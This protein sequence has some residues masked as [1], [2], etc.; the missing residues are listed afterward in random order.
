MGTR[1]LEKNDAREMMRDPMV[2]QALQLADRLR[3]VKGEDLE[4]DEYFAISE[5][6]GVSEEYIRFLEQNKSSNGAQNFLDR[7]RT[8]FFSLDTDTRRYVSTGILATLF[9]MLLAIGLKIDTYTAFALKSNY[10]VFQT[11]S[12]V[13]AIGAFYNAAVSKSVKSA[14]IVGGIFGGLSYV[15]G[16]VFAMIMFIPNLNFPPPLVIVCA[17]AC[18]LLAMLLQMIFHGGKKGGSSVDRTS[19]RQDLLKQLVDL[20]EHLREGQQAATFLSLDVVGSTKMKLG[21]DPLSVEFTFTEY[22]NYVARIAEKHFG[23]IHSTA[24]DGITVAFEHP[25]NAFN[26]ARQIQ[27]GLVEFNAF[28]NKI[29]TPLQLRAGI[30][31]GQVLAPEAGNMNSINFASVIDIAAHLQ[32]ECPIGGVAVSDEAGAGLNGGPSV[33]GSERVCVHDTWATVWK[34]KKSLDHF[35]MPEPLAQN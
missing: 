8:Q 3:E 12:Y 35:K 27:T 17:G 21:A 30:H 33:I 10:S 11:I 25:Q 20:Q 16:S 22:H 24:G 2:L 31:T 26:A 1:V 7:L 32:K 23:N 29:D 28:R 14:A 19:A 4:S 5:A 18:A 15:L 13:L 9:S 6:T 34:R